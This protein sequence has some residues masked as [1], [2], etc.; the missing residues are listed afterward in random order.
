VKGDL[1]RQYKKMPFNNFMWFVLQNIQWKRSFCLF[2][3]QQGQINQKKKKK[4]KKVEKK[5]KEED[6]DLRMT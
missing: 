4:Q 3:E 6:E 5:Q 1:I 2:D